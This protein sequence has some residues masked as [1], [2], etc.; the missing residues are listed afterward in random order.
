M[1]S[2]SG[3]LQL[4]ESLMPLLQGNDNDAAVKYL[5]LLNGSPIESL[6]ETQYDEGMAAKQECEA[7]IEGRPVFPLMTDNHPL[8]IRNLQ[9]LIY[10][11]IVREKTQLSG[12]VTD[13]ILQRM[14][15]EAQLRSTPEGQMI[16]AM[17]RG[18]TEPQNPPPPQP[19]GPPPSQAAAQ[20]NQ[21]M[22]SAPAQPAEPQ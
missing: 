19:Q 14:K 9:R 8:F 21:P 11:P 6:Y 5:S 13:L 15:M 22:T 2:I 18:S 12:Q 4:G 17:T 20:V 10:N 1:N 7:M 3:R 16:I